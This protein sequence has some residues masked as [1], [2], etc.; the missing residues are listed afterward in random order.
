MTVI[1]V[2][3]ERDLAEKYAGRLIFMADG[4]VIA[5]QPNSARSAAGVQT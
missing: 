2:T 3:H 5:D 1:L 4:K